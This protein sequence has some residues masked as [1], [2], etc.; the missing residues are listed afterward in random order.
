MTVSVQFVGHELRRIS[1][2]C[3]SL[4]RDRSV[5]I[6]QRNAKINHVLAMYLAGT[7]QCLYVMDISYYLS[8]VNLSSTT[9]ATKRQA[10]TDVTLMG[11]LTVDQVLVG[12]RGN[13]SSVARNLP[14]VSQTGSGFDCGTTPAG[15]DAANKESDGRK[16][17]VVCISENVSNVLLK[18][19]VSEILV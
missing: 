18:L 13:M 12:R 4:Y 19:M 8:W 15:V 11:F 10:I 9:R 7:A 6:A 2:V 3:R 14:W 17:G 1:D 16:H 5:D